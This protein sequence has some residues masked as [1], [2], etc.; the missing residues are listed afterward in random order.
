[1]KYVLPVLLCMSSILHAEID[2]QQ[3]NQKQPAYGHYIKIL[4]TPNIDIKKSINTGAKNLSNFCYRNR[5]EL[6]QL[7]IT[8]AGFGLSSYFG[9]TQ[10]KA[11]LTCIIVAGASVALVDNNALSRMEADVPSSTGRTD[12]KKYI[13]AITALS[14]GYM[15]YVAANEHDKREFQEC[16]TRLQKAAQ[17]A[18]ESRQLMR[19][20]KALADTTKSNIKKTD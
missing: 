1:M 8:G 17:D 15:S 2:L 3:S 5:P 12:N 14:I 6:L 16:L 13:M 10:T 11:R 18:E 7:I 4:F 9:E 20:I 19:E